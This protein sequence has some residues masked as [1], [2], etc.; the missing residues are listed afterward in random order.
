[1][2]TAIIP[3]RGGSKRIPGKNIK[4]FCG[5][6][7]IAWSIE[8]AIES[9]LFD[10]VIVSTD[11]QRIKHVAESFGAEVPF[12]RPAHLA[13]DQTGTLEVIQH[14]I[15]FLEGEGVKSEWL[16]CIYPTAPLLQITHLKEAFD[17]L[18]SKN[19]DYVFPVSTFDFNIQRALIINKNNRLESV[20]P[21]YNLTRTQDLKE[22]YHDAGQFYWGKRDAFAE[23]K[24]IYSPVSVPLVIPSIFVRDI[25][26]PED[27]EVAEFLFDYLKKKKKAE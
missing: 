20:H 23:G 11:D 9:G 8:N 16:C 26:T 27:W 12:L 15:K 6:P 25:D 2:K 5:K 3:A 13:D 19:A 4:D 24:T 1:M 7:M 10:R 14:A 17:L 22:F 18:N 21:E